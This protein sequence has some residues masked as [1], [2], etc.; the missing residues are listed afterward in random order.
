MS[1]HKIDINGKKIN[2]SLPV[3][4]GIITQENNSI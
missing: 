4:F 3:D 1:F 2:K